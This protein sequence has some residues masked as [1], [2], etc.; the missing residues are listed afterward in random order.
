MSNSILNN[1]KDIST[2]VQMKYIFFTAVFL[3]HFL[4]CYILSAVSAANFYFSTKICGVFFLW[5]DAYP[6]II[7]LEIHS[8]RNDQRISSLCALEADVCSPE[9]QLSWLEHVTTSPSLRGYLNVDLRWSGPQQHPSDSTPSMERCVVMR[10]SPGPVS[11][12]KV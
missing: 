4:S 10:A 6:R 12:A 9:R 11:T 7:F 8:L 5:Q 1:S 2:N 3:K